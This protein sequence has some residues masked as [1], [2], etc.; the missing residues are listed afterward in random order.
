MFRKNFY[1]AVTRLHG[2]FVRGIYFRH[3]SGR[4]KLFADYNC[5]FFFEKNSHINIENWLDFGAKSIRHN[6]RSSILRMDEGACFNIQDRAQIFYGADIILFKD[7]I[8]DIGHSFINSDCKIR[9]HKHIRIGDG[10]A[11]SHDVTIMDSDAHYIEGDNH[12]NPVNIGNRVWIGT[13]VLI[14]NGV[15]IGDG[16]VIA[17]GSVVTKDVPAGALAGGTPA[18][19]IKE[20]VEWSE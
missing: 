20:K 1:K 10:C 11:I 8:L 2:R 7:A 17:A 14:M 13:R 3:F 16:A 15:T 4:G 9:C 12:T 6:G 19:I 5:K 18:K